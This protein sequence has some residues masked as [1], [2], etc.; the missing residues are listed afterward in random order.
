MI[1]VML[2]YSSSYA[3]G[4]DLLHKFPLLQESPLIHT[5]KVA[6]EE[7]LEQAIGHVQKQEVDKA[8]KLL[9]K[10]T[11]VSSKYKTIKD[12]QELIT[13]FERFRTAVEHEN[14]ALAYSMAEHVNLDRRYQ[15][16]E[17]TRPA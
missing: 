4:Y 6:W 16:L 17:L 8:Q 11:N 5:L 2:L 12:F 13:H 9:N 3:Q 14:Y 10:F 1:F 7:I 15:S